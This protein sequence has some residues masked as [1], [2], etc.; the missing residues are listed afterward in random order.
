MELNSFNGVPIVLFLNILP[1]SLQCVSEIFRSHFLERL[2]PLCSLF[3][4]V[5]SGRGEDQLVLKAARL[6]GQLQT[7]ILW[8]RARP[9][10]PASSVHLP[11]SSCPSCQS[12]LWTTHRWHNGNDGGRERR[13]KGRDM[14][15]RNNRGGR[16]GTCSTSEK[17]LPNNGHLC[18]KDTWFCP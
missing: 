6:V 11:L 17:V 3:P 18:I 15:C 5:W 16:E 14:E 1:R 13:E 2:E 4:G 7:D 8:V 10:L 12:S 9:L